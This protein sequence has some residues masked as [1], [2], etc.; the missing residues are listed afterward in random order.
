MSKNAELKNQYVVYMDEYES[1]G[2]MSE[3]TPAER[4]EN[5]PY[6]LLPHHAVYK[7]NSPTKKLRVVVDRSVN[8]LWH[9]DSTLPITIS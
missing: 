4:D 3:I 9:K 8:I 6:F 5:S 1:H 7:D 2:H